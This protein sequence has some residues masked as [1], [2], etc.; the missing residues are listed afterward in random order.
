MLCT[1][2]VVVEE[3]IKVVRMSVEL[4]S[5]DIV[6]IVELGSTEVEGNIS[7]IFCKLQSSS[8]IRAVPIIVPYGSR[9]Q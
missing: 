9:S 3:G 8:E 4:G 1:L 6:V 5:V 2:L 7:E